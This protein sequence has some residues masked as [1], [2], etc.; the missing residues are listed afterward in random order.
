MNT[1]SA[2]WTQRRVHCVHAAEEAP[3]LPAGSVH[4]AEPGERHPGGKRQATGGLCGRKGH[5]DHQ[6]GEGGGQGLDGSPGMRRLQEEQ[7]QRHWQPI[8]VLCYGQESDVVDGRLNATGTYSL[9][10]NYNDLQIIFY[11]IYCLYNNMH[12][13][14]LDVYKR[15]ASRRFGC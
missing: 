6:Q 7:T 4:P 2:E 5:G 9:T 3:Q 8:Q 12:L 14:N 11:T 13:I 15:E 1:S 10:L